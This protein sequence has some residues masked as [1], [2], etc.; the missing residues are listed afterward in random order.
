[1]Q[2][3]TSPVSRALVVTTVRDDDDHRCRDVAF[4]RC[5]RIAHTFVKYDHVKNRETKRYARRER[6][7]LP[8]RR[9]QTMFFVG[10]ENEINCVKTSNM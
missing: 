10:T 1:M 3:R 5:V 4:A 6:N 7:C 2:T 9:A 8:R